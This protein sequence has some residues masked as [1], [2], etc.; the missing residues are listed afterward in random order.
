MRAKLFKLPGGGVS[1]PTHQSTEAIKQ[2]WAKMIAEDELT[3]GEPCAPHTLT[4]LAIVNGELK[5][6]QETVYGRKIPLKLLREKLLQKHRAYMRLHSDSELFSMN[7]EQQLECYKDW[8]IQLPKETSLENLQQNLAE[9]ERTRTL[10]VWHDH[11]T[12]AG[13]GYVLITVKVVYDKAVFQDCI[14]GNS[15][16]NIKGIIE[17]PEIHV[18]AL[19]SSSQEDQAALISDRKEC[20]KEVTL[21]LTT[22]DGI[23]ITDR[24]FFFLGD[25]PAAQF[26]CGTQQGGYYKCGSCGCHANLMDGLGYSLN[27]KWR[28]LRHLQALVLAGKSI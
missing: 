6:K 19:S 2:D 14:P 22:Q 24:L 1:V 18:I 15:N 25:K 28:S 8:N 26:E 7:K 3:L 11:A 17:E 10:A 5:T 9:C 20:L 12:I 13:K 4:K 16:Q 23:E 21:K 27:C